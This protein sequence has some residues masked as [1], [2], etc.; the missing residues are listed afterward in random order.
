MKRYY[1]VS[2]QYS[3]YTYCANIAH[4]DSIQDVEKHY[5]K[6]AWS[7]VTE[8][9][10]YD[11]EEAK[12]KGMPIIEIESTQEP[13]EQNQET[14]TTEE[15]ENGTMTDRY[16]YLDAVTNDVRD[17]IRDE[18]ELADWTG[19]RDGLEEKLNDDLWINDSVTGNASGSYYCNTWRAEEALAHNLD[20]I[21]EV[22][23]EFG[24]EATISD[25]YEHG[26][27]WWDVTIR[28]YYLGQAIGAAL[29]ELEEAGAFDEADEAETAGSLD[30]IRD[31]MR[32]GFNGIAA[33][34]S[35]TTTAPEVATI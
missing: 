5:S 14:T 10:E 8:A 26:A 4:A 31:R 16:N 35:N 21:A 33:A 17:Y 12:T 32:D 29:D 9:T 13:E 15:K 19:D 6:Y 1:K 11:V 7:N 24:I 2:F 30:G 23:A 22:A 20:L 34:V 18:I 3:E 25:G 27:E 28:C